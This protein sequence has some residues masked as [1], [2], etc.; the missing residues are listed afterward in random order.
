MEEGQL[1]N[2]VD[3]EQDLETGGPASKS[4]LRY[5]LAVWPWAS[6]LTL[7]AYPYYSSALE[8]IHSIDSKTEGEG[9]KK[10]R[11]KKEI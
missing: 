5:F 10:K 1:G 4:G 7:I 9:L 3:W 8:Q 11:K 6:H 2:S